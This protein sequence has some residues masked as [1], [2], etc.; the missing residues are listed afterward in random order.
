[1][2]INIVHKFNIMGFFS[3][4]FGLLKR[5]FSRDTRYTEEKREEKDEKK[6]IALTK[7]Q[8]RIAKEE[9]KLIKKIIKK[10]EKI[11]RDLQKGTLTPN[12]IRKDRKN[13]KEITVEQ[14]LIVLIFYLKRLTKTNVSIKQEEA[15]LSKM[16]TYWFLVRGGLLDTTMKR[17]VVNEVNSLFVK[18]GVELKLE[19][20]LTKE[21][22]NLMNDEYE[23]LKKEKG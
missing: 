16:R 18:L 13:K 22:I 4:I 8:E 7:K 14:A 17:G 15:T 1:M 6:S 21:K 2:F 19:E 23:L 9:N 5:L 20:K 12:P 11:L 10:L 3:L